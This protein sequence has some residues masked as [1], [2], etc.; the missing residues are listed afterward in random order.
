V[1]GKSNQAL[2]YLR[3]NRAEICLIILNFLNH[4]CNFQIPDPPAG[5]A[6]DLRL[7]SS[8]EGPQRSSGGEFK[9]YPLEACIFAAVR[10]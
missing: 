10:G 5:T 1:P 4:T 9:L 6:W 2:A 3:Q 8:R 7:S